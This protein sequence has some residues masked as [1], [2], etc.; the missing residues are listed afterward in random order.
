MPTTA[1]STSTVPIS[2]AEMV[3]LTVG[4]V[5]I[6]RPTFD[7]GYA[8]KNASS[9][10]HLLQDLVTE[11]V[12]GEQ[13]A[14]NPAA[15]E[16][17]MSTL[18]NTNLDWLIILQATFADSTM[19]QQIAQ[20]FSGIPLLL[21]AIPEPRTGGRLRANSFCGINL[22]GYAL[23]RQRIPYY[24]WFSDPQDL[25]VS[26]RL[27]E[28]LRQPSPTPPTTHH[29]LP[30]STSADFTPEEL[31]QANEHID[32]LGT[33]Q[34]GVI[35]EHP[36][37]F[38]PCDYDPRQVYQLTGVK[39][40]QLPLERLFEQADQASVQDL[41]WAQQQANQLVGVEELGTDQIKPSLRIH[42][43]LKNL[44]ISNQWSGVAL[45]CWPECFDT[46]QGAA[47]TPLSLLSETG[48]VGCCEADMYGVLTGLLLY[49]LSQEP[50]WIADLVDLDVS[51]HTGVFW[52]CGLAPNSMADPNQP[53]EATVHS[54]RKLPLLNQ[55]GL[56]PGRVTIAR[57][58]QHPDQTR[59]V[60]GGGTVLAEPRPFTGTAGVV[61][62]DAP[63]Q[64]VLDRIMSGGLEHH[65]GLAYGDYQKQLTVIAQALDIPVYRL[66]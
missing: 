16:Q 45:R 58:S 36:T 33:K 59:L 17:R 27:S 62:F 54:N 28:L 53:K 20:T 50:V 63:S 34:V 18:S 38:E 30:D 14:T 24:W 44:A 3:P 64:T 9:A 7:L 65:Y 42:H 23:T 40:D 13:L 61:R 19:V 56:K 66:T 4:F 46:Y 57:I 52:H 32:Q 10:F 25:Q 60:I 47:C 35:G 48:I 11:T 55:F 8:Q 2:T 41:I 29:P 12:G 6:A 49:Q 15:L 39:V 1:T 22:A 26:D 51:D 31:Q 37:G 43:A 5:A 21:W